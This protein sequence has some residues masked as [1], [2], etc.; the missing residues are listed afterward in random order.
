MYKVATPFHIS[1]SDAYL[2]NTCIFFLSDFSPPG[3]YE[4][5][6]YCELGL[7]S[8]LATILN[9]LSH[10]Q[11]LPLDLQAFL[12]CPICIQFECLQLVRALCLEMLGPG[13]CPLSSGACRSTVSWPS[14][15]EPSGGVGAGEERAG[16][17]FYKQV[18]R[19]HRAS[20]R[21][22][23]SHRRSRWFL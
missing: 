15:E 12:K 19:L 17:C 13:C 14:F 6:S 3:G 21:P 16:S 4:V 1:T 5:A 9:N 2:A 11:P 18:G 10:V 22:S 7:H 23:S 20:P 8:L